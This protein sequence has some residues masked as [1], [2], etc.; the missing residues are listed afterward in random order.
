M[1]RIPMSEI[2]RLKLDVST[3]RLV[4]AAGI[5]LKPHG[6]DLVG[7]CPFH[8]DRTPSLVISPKA[9]LWHCLGKCQMGGSPIDWVMR[10]EG[11]PFR[12]AVELL[13]HQ[14]GTA[15]ALDAAPRPTVETLASA[16]GANGSADADASASMLDAMEQA[17][18]SPGGAPKGYGRML[19]AEASTI[20]SADDQALLDRVI[21]FYHETLKQSPEAQAYLAARGLSHPEV[22]DHF[23]LGFANRTLGYR[24]P[25][26][27]VKTGAA[28]RG[29]LQRIGIYRGTGHEHFNGSLT[30]PIFDAQ[31]SA[32]G[33]ALPAVAA[34]AGCAGAADAD[35]H[36]VEVY[37]R[38]V[39]ERL[40]EGTPL[41]LYLPGPHRGVF[42][43]QGLA[44]QQEAIL[45]EALI[46]ALTFWCAGYRNVTSSYGIEG[47]TP[48]ILAA[49]KRHGIR[50][51]LIAYD[52]D[53]AGNAAAEKLASKLIADGFECYRILFPKGMD[54]NEYALHVQPAGKSLSLVIRQAEW[55][56]TGTPPPR[57]PPGVREDAPIAATTVDAASVEREPVAVVD[58]PSLVAELAAPA[59]PAPAATVGS[60]EPLAHPCASEA[61]KQEIAVESVVEPIAPAAV[62]PPL[63]TP[64]PCEVTAR[65][66]AIVLG[67]R[68]YRVRGLDKN[69]AYDTLKVNVM[70]SRNEGLHVDTFD[71][72]QAKAR[73]LFVR[74]AAVEI[75]VEEAIV[76][77]DLGQVLLVLEQQ[78]DALI[79]RQLRA[80]RAAPLPD[81]A[82]LGPEDEAAAFA[83]LRDPNLV[84]RIVADFERCGLVGEP[85]NALVGYLAAVSR[86]LAAP[87]AI[88]IQSTS[89]AGKSALMD[90]VLRFV[91]E[92]ERVHY[93]AMTG[94]SLFY[95][96]E[97]DLKHKILA[98]AEEE[99]VRQA[100]YALKLL[101]SQGELT[102]ASTGKDPATGKL[103]TE[104]YR[105][106]GPVMLFLTT[107]AIDVDE[108]LLNRCLVLTIDES[109]EQTRAIQARQRQRRTLDGLLAHTEAD[110]LATL[111]RHAQ[112]LLR[113]VSVVNPYADRLGFLDDR[114][115]TRRDH[116]KY[117]T[118]IDAIAF[119]HQ[120]QRPIHVVE[121]RGRRIEYVQ[122]QPEDIALANRLAHEV[123]GRSLDELPPQTR[124][125]LGIVRAYVA[126]RCAA[127]AIRQADLRFTRRE[128]RE[129]AGSSEAQLRLHLERLVELEYLL[130][131]RG[132]RGQ[133]FVYELV[134]DG[135]IGDAA[136]RLPGLI[137]VGALPQSPGEASSDPPTTRSSRGLE[138]EF[139]E[140]AGEFVGPSRAHRGGFVA[141]SRSPE[142]ARKPKPDAASG[143]LFG[144]HASDARPGKPNGASR[145]TP[146][147]CRTPIPPAP[148]SSV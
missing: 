80:E 104:E 54:A 102:I 128:L 75:G 18:K 41:H 148:V 28:I 74:L 2:E 21:G 86:K 101:Q 57:E 131:H 58:V 72:Y 35:G 84:E 45:C 16:S 135:D 52:R 106:E 140:L 144:D 123:L 117:L 78:Q 145:R 1:A 138:G 65:D 50:R 122:V 30:I 34:G 112:Q 61:A 94:Q 47:F 60:A 19:Q 31:G 97:R 99:G 118:L 142:T 22:V 44:D 8:D 53:D 85:T 26:M 88:L 64:I 93:S 81:I 38:K 12:R 105:V 91:P 82:A 9:N 136:P 29:A 13:R 33:S 115:R 116:Q 63:P 40:R 27:Q 103:V 4:E 100:A 89:A 113:P 133:S 124:R 59:H 11:V 25:D 127:L 77:R 43:E 56:G 96:G 66:V 126:E 143:E 83:L 6:K 141:G 68:R 14:L 98:I 71:L 134:F 76:Q 125:L 32:S 67:D 108:E 49:L 5:A 17:P 46:D 73:A 10:F 107:T 20:A 114:T 48:D 51:V 111:H 69:L 121:H 70:V 15:P 147:S 36:V 55:I 39:G 87:L 7:R 90:A 129:R 92:P 95:L 109:R 139:A 110:A 137:D 146:A 120:H 24:L 23:K 62:L 79:Q 119:L 42:N 130:P 132:Q 3:V 37:G